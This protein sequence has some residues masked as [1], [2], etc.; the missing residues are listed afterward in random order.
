MLIFLVDITYHPPVDWMRPMVAPVDAHF[1]SHATIIYR[2]PL[3]RPYF[4]RL[5]VS[6]CNGDRRGRL[7][8]ACGCNICTRC[9]GGAPLWLP[10]CLNR[11]TSACSAIDVVSRFFQGV[12]FAVILRARARQG[13]ER[14]LPVAGGEVKRGMKA[15]TRGSDLAGARPAEGDP[16][17]AEAGVY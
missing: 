4:F 12:G 9:S 10:P 1:V 8:C 5:S 17:V 3:G 11:A 2:V 16:D 6:G 14:G 13:G 7:L 15:F